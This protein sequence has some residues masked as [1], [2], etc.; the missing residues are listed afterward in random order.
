MTVCT[1]TYLFFQNLHVIHT[2]PGGGFVTVTLKLSFT[3]DRIDVNEIKD[4]S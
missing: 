1:L 2:T 4:I 3:N